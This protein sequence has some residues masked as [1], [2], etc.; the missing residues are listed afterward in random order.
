MQ[1][2]GFL[3][4]SRSQS[5]VAKQAKLRTIE[6]VGYGLRSWSISWYAGVKK[7]MVEG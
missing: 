2:T 7:V 3:W 5:R 6:S 1:A 4:K